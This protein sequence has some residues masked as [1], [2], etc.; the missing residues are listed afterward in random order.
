MDWLFCLN[1]KC[2]WEHVF[3][4]FSNALEMKDFGM[5]LLLFHA[6]TVTSVFSVKMWYF[7]LVHFGQTVLWLIHTTINT[8]TYLHYAVPYFFKLLSVYQTH[9][10]FI[11]SLNF[12]L[13]CTFCS[14]KPQTYQ[15]FC[16]N[17]NL[18]GKNKIKNK[19]H[20][21][22]PH[23]QSLGCVCYGPLKNV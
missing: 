12:Y 15:Y 7:F 1:C 5:F 22:N 16:L 21:L 3:W 18:W 17:L 23:N 19:F 8:R 9:S 11:Y 10:V 4:H 2:M 14:L 20:D 6:D 13:H